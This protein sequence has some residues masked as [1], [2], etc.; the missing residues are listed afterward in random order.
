ME[1]IT[2]RQ[3]SDP[4]P[5][6][7]QTWHTGNRWLGVVYLILSLLM[8]GFFIDSLTDGPVDTTRKLLGMAVEAALFV[9]WAYL[10][11]V[12][13]RSRVRVDG[14][15]VHRLALVRP[16]TLRWDQ[17]AEVRRPAEGRPQVELVR[18]DGQVIAL[19]KSAGQLHQ[20]RQHAAGAPPV[21]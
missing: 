7:P 13:L 18:H 8:A 12:E 16:R 15:G 4:H 19:P 3:A 2:G 6:A 14:E 1:P 17:I 5:P 20:L 11:L 9:L 10:G 21:E